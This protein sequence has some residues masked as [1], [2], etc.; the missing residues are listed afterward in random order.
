MLLDTLSPFLNPGTIRII[1]SSHT[2]EFT[3][4]GNNILSISFPDIALVDSLH[5]FDASSGFIQFAIKPLPGLPVGT[6]IQNTA[7]IYFDQNSPILTNLVQTE[8]LGP[9]GTSN[10]N[11][12]TDIALF[13]NPTQQYCTVISKKLSEQSHLEL[14]DI[15]GK[16]ISQIDI[17]ES[18]YTTIDLTSYIPGT[19]LVCLI[20]QNKTIIRKKLI[21]Y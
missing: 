4:I 12:S 14:F 10:L 18:G 3:L 9:S 19:Y 8:I 13:P 20:S 1:N 6:F 2:N 17:H 15:Y 16:K 7:S 11:P 5:N 21:R